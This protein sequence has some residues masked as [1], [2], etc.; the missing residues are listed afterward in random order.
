MI[1][2]RMSVIFTFALAVILALLCWIIFDL[3]QTA[4]RDEVRADWEAQKAADAAANARAAKEALEVQA[5]LL[6]HIDEIRRSHEKS[7]AA[8]DER[9]AAALDKLR[10]RASRPADYLPVSAEAAGSVAAAGCGA[11]S[12]FRQDSEVVVG[13]ARDADITRASLMEC[14]SAYEAAQRA[15]R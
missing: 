7:I 1:G 13:I 2:G 10:K 14:R 6:R 5:G 15:T 12:L 4:G 3:G 11:D 8:I 9:H